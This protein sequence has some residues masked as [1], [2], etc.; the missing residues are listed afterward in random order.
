MKALPKILLVILIL[1][2]LA[3]V[4][5]GYP[6]EGIFCLLLAILIRLD[7]LEAAIR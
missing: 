6:Q 4:V 5:L 2:A 1:L 3:A 7:A